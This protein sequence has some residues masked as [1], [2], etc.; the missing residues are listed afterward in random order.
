[1][2]DDI[3]AIARHGLNVLREKERFIQTKLVK[4]ARMPRK[5]SWQL[6]QIILPK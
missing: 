4:D 6:I 3:A 1:M 5:I 2:F